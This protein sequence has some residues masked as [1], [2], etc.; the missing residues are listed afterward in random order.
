MFIFPPA[1]LIDVGRLGADL[2]EEFV[3]HRFEQPGGLVF[4]LAEH[5][6]GVR[7]AQE[8]AGQRLDL[9]FAESIGAGQQAHHRSQA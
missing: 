5:A 6:G 3:H 1:G 2:F 7:Q 4:P 9:P 8:V